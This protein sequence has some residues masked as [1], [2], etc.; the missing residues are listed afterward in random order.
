MSFA[1][2]EGGSYFHHESIHG[3]RFRGRIRHSIYAPELQAADL[4]GFAALV[5]AD[6]IHP[7]VLR[8][9]RRVLVEYLGAGGTL[10]V[11]GENRAHQWVPQVEWEFRPT[12]FWSWLDKTHNPGFVAATPDHPIFHHVPPRDFVWHYHGLLKVPPGAIPVAEI[13]AEADPEGRGGAIFYD[14][15]NVGGTTGR[16]VISTLDPFYHNGSFFMPA[17][18][19]FLAGLLDWLDAEFG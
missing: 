16:L 9:K 18:T 2:L 11:L 14:H 1:V 3:E 17:A 4:C 15:P 10:V 5:V 13:A 8:A 19:R 6:R 7:A 12:N